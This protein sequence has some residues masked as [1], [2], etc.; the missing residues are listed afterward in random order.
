MLNRLPLPVQIGQNVPPNIFRLQRR[1]LGALK[2]CRTALQSFSA[3]QELLALLEMLVHRFVGVPVAKEGFAV[4][5]KGLEL[6]LDLVDVGGVVPE[7]HVHFGAGRGW[8]VL[9]LHAHLVELVVRRWWVNRMFLTKGTV[10][11]LPVG[12]IGL[13]G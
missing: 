7:A 2:P 13:L 8:D 3:R 9:L 10:V 6:A 1:P 5:G 4:I 12:I 11:A